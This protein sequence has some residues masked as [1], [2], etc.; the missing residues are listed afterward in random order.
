MMARLGWF[1]RQIEN[2]LLLLAFLLMIVVAV[3]Q[4]IL[5]HT[6]QGGLMWADDFL[7]IEV[8]WLA[9]L[10]A[11]VAS[12]DQHHLGLDIAQRFLP[13]AWAQ[14]LRRLVA[15][16]VAA[17]SAV[18]SVVTWQFV[19]LDKDSGVYAFAQV[20]SWMAESI[21]PLGFALISMHYARHA[22]RVRSR[23]HGS[24]F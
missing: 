15:L 20:P 4:I 16:S 10:G 1:L 12:R 17:L 8:L 18:L 5:R 3:L 13:P 11:V 19:Q 24:W 9:V 2:I 22:L 14:P 21:L 23:V 6:A 7:R